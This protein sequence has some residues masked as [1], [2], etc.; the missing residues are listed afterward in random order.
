[1]NTNQHIKPHLFRSGKGYTF[2][3]KA[4]PIAGEGKEKR[5]FV[6]ICGHAV[7]WCKDNTGFYLCNATQIDVRRN[8]RAA[9]FYEYRYDTNSRHN[10]HCQPETMTLYGTVHRR[11]WLD[12]G[13]NWFER[14]WLSDEAT[15]D[16]DGNITVVNHR[17]NDM[18][19]P[20][21]RLG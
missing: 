3:P 16:A 10:P 17:M 1:M 12:M 18:V 15:P 20:A 5:V 7:V 14:V 11:V 6:C 8:R 19:V 9:S 21:V 2:Q 4:S 13:H